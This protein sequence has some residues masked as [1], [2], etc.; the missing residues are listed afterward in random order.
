MKRAKTK[1][2]CS[3]VPLD[4]L[5]RLAEVAS[6]L[7]GACPN[8]TSCLGL[9]HIDGWEPEGG[10]QE[11]CSE[12]GRDTDSTWRCWA[13]WAQSLPPNVKGKGRE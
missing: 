11:H 9:E 10:C 1:A 4:Q 3:S 7:S 12:E 2:G 6:I 8:D 5:V 13:E